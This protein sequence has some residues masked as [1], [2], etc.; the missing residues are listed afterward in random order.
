[1]ISNYTDA[2]IKMLELH[3]SK[4]DKR[5]LLG[6]FNVAV[7]ENHVNSFCDSYNL[8]NL[9]K[10]STCYN[11][12]DKPTSIDQCTQNFP[13]NVCFRNRAVWFPLDFCYAKEFLKNW[14]LR[15]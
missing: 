13:K 7:D 11:N 1:M 3:S 12:P 9:I 6:N 2:L 15:S 14:F 5:V 8:K 10:Q 4:D